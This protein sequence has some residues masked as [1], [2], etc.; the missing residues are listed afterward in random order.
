[1]PA[2][3][4]HLVAWQVA[5]GNSPCCPCIASARMR[6]PR[7]NAR[8]ILHGFPIGVLQVHPHRTDIAQAQH[9]SVTSNYRSDKAEKVEKVSKAQ[10]LHNAPN[11]CTSMRYIIQHQIPSGRPVTDSALTASASI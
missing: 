2:F 4:I 8:C 7:G 10:Q 9:S 6:A 1:M 11:P 3:I 5:S